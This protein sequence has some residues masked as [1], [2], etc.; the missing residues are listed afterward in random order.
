MIVLLAIL[1][2][3]FVS[4]LFVYVR[5]RSR[6]GKE[7]SRRVAYAF[8]LYVVLIILLC[9]AGAILYFKQTTGK[10]VDSPWWPFLATF[11]SLFITSVVL[12]VAA[13]IRTSLMSRKS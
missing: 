9:C 12:F 10:S 2:P 13:F 11:S 1:L 8:D 5:V 6:A 3:L 4:A 7:A